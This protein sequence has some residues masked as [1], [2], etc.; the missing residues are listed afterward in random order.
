MF[1]WDLAAVCHMQI[2]NP[3][4][5]N[6]SLLTT[7]PDSGKKRTVEC[8]ALNGPPLIT[9]FKAQVTLGKRS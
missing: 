7:G 1:E 2:E 3:Q 6:G 8:S 4:L 9:L 5:Q